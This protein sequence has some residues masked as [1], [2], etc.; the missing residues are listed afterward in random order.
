MTDKTGKFCALSWEEYKA[1]SEVHTNKDLEI[2]WEHARIIQRDL[3]GQVSQWLK[4]TNMG[5]DWEQADRFRE[6]CIGESV[7]IAPFT[8]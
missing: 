2:G 6:S 8:A 1:M 4:I 3:N 5:K 7:N